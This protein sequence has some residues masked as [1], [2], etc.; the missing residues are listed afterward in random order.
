ADLERALDRVEE[1]LF[2][3]GVPFGARPSL[4]RRP[5]S[6]A[7]HDA[8]DVHRDA[9]RVDALD[10]GSKL[11]GTGY[12]PSL[13]K[14]RL[15]RLGKRWRWFGTALRVNDRYA[16]LNGNYVAAAVTLAAFVSLFP[17]ILV[18]IAVI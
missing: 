18:I 6:V 2:A 10:H 15:E 7:V 3:G 14:K 11:Q 4:S 12:V 9:R 1:S 13:V 16:E 8:R 17:L 5:A